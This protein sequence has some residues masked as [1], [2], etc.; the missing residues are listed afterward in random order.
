MKRL[1]TIL[2]VIVLAASFLMIAGPGTS[3]AKEYLFKYANTQSDNHPRSKSMVFFKNM[4]EKASNGQIKVELYFS[5]VLGKEA[6]VL[7]MRVRAP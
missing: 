1:T 4:V 5:G 2:F 7:D 6:E 3:V